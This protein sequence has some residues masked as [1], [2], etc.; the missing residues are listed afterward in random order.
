MNNDDV[1]GPYQ[2]RVDAFACECKSPA[3]GKPGLFAR[4]RNLRKLFG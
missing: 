3:D 4:V 1:C 2:H